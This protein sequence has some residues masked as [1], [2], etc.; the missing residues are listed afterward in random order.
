[1]AFRTMDRSLVLIRFSHKAIMYSED[2]RLFY[3]MVRS[4]PFWSLKAI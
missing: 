2:R 4:C 1:M 3:F